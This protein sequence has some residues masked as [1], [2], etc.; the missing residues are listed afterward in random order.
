MCQDVSV[1]QQSKQLLRQISG[2]DTYIADNSYF[3]V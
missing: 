3:H 2:H 1:L